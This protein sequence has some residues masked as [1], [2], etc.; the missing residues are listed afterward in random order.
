MSLWRRATIS[1]L[2]MAA[3]LCSLP[4][5]AQKAEVPVTEVYLDNGMNI[6]MV[7]RHESPTITAGW[8]TRVG[9]VNEEVGAT[10]I[11][12]LFDHMMFK[13]SLTIGTKNFA[14]ESEIME[15][16]DA[17]RVEPS[18]QLAD[19]QLLGADA[20]EAEQ[21]AGVE[22]ARRADRVGEAGAEPVEDGLERR[23]A[24]DRDLDHPLVRHVALG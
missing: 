21:E 3:L 5:V 18:E 24:L 19:L 13:G 4:A 16:L 17:L 20:L 6:L 22:L 14:K 10:G 2:A 12:H 9:S 23:Q 1:L 11:A 8:V 15:K 7:E